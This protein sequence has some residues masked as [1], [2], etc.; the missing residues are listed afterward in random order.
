MGVIMQTF[1]WNC[2]SAENQE[3]N[4]WNFIKDKIPSLHNIGFTAIWLP[5]CNKA[6]SNTS[7]GYDP[8]DYYD[9]GDIDQKGSQKTWFGSKDELVALISAAHT[10]NIQ[11]YADL[12]IHQNSGADEE[13]VNG[14]DGVTRWT[15]FTPKSLKFPRAWQD[16][17]P[18]AYETIDGL[19]PITFGGMPNLCHRNPDVYTALLEYS[20]WLLDEIGFDG[21]RYDCVKGY[22]GW[23]VRAIQELR[24]VK[25][26][27]PYKPFGVGECWDGQYTIEEWL[28]ETNSWSDNPCCAFDFNLRYRLKDLCDTEGFSLTT[29]TQGGTLLNDGQSSIAVTFVENHDVVRDDAIINDKMLAYAFILTHEGYPCVFWQDYYNWNLAQEDNDSGIAALIKV[30]ENYAGGK[31]D[32]L[33]CD[34]NLYIMQREGYSNQMGLVFVLNNTGEWNGTSVQTQWR[35]HKF[36]PA[37]WR[38]KDNTDVPE[39]KFT[40]SNGRIDFWA[41]PRGYVVYVC[42]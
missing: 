33:Y 42:Q 6:A 29:L 13:E 31:T 15:K 21:F 25:N 38:G 26:N 4:W 41:P 3:F 12:V 14:I 27:I 16:F 35:N 18:S 7:M 8:Y 23:M 20:R 9:L 36:T 34:D 10:N 24:G 19:D 22:G 40:D 2:P 30:H 28:N 1:Y 37:A 17:Q 32:I 39:D 5:P 11:V